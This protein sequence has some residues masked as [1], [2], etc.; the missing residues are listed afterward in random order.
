MEFAPSVRIRKI[1]FFIGPFLFILLTTLNIGE[2]INPKAPVTFGLMFWMIGWWIT[3]AAPMAVVALL[4]LIVFPAFGVLNMETAAVPYANQSVFLFMGGFLIALAL[5]KHKLHERIALHLIH[6]SGTSSK[7]IIAGFSIATGV[8]SMWISNTA[9]AMMMLPIALSVIQLLNQNDTHN[10]EKDKKNFALALLLSIGYMASIGGM[11]TIIG[12]PPNTA[13]VGY[14]KDFYNHDITFG[15]WILI[16]LPV[17]L[18]LGLSCY[19]LIVYWLFPLNL[20]RIEGSEKIVGN[21]LL[22]LGK[23]QRGEKLVLIVFSC[24][25]LAWIFQLPLNKLFGS[26]FLNDTNIAIAGGVAM[27]LV[28]ERWSEFT[29]LL[30]WEDTKKL[31]WGILLLFGGGICLAKGMGETGIIRF[32]GNTIASSGSL[33]L[34]VLLLIIIFLSVVM[35]EIL[36]NIALVTI[37]IPVVFGIAESY[38]INPILLGLPVTFAASSGYMLP[39][40]TPPN[41]IVFSSGHIRMKDMVKAGFWLDLASIIIIFSLSW[42]LLDKINL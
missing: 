36:S 19:L 33:S 9:T 39:I 14:V 5:E 11:A 18:L 17:A 32:I 23:I 25:A 30:H 15:K 22:A 37:F 38:N 2:H 41:A 26:D 42:L 8:L 6:F 12:T 24:T 16:G 31:P 3:E 10:T 21:K 7:G 40:S 1:G 4:P 28:P 20:K 35:T 34:V 29:F 27:F 13:F